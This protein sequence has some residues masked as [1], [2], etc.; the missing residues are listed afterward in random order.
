MSI[1]LLAP[2]I[3]AF[4]VGAMSPGPSLA[5]VLRNSLVGGRRHGVTTALGHGIGFGV[6]AFLAAAGMAA[7]FSAN[8]DLVQVLKWGGIALLVYLGFTFAKK[9]RSESA[10]EI[11]GN[12]VRFSGRSSLAQ[13]LLVALLNPKIL[14]WMIA[15][16]S[17]LIDSDLEITTLLGIAIIGMTI[18][19][20]WYVTVALLMTSSNRGARLR[21]AS[22]KLDGAMAFLMFAFAGLLVFDLG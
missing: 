15:I 16:Y 1:D 14:A 4:V 21:A 7:A 12:T 18:D 20:S 22:N 6:Y 5:M 8:A 10:Q 11:E 17:P 19:G 9:S 3:A 13:G 2:L